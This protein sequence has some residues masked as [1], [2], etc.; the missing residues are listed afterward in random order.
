MG[1]TKFFG[2][3][4]ALDNVSFEV[5]NGE[6]VGYVGLNG[7]GKT[8]T[9]R[10]ATGVLPPSSGDV[11]IDG[12]SIVRN[13][14]EASR[15]IGWVPEL[16]I[17]EGDFKALDYFAY[18]AGYYGYS[19]SEAR[20]L[21]RDLL[22]KFGLGEALNLKLSAYSQGMRK[23]FALA[24]SMINDPPNFLFDE[25]LNGLD[26]RGIAFFRELTLDF[27][28][29][30]RA[31]FF[32]SHILSEVEGLADRV[33]FI[34]KGRIIGVYSMEEVKYMAKPALV[35]KLS[36][37]RNEAVEFMKKYGEVVALEG[38]RYLVRGFIGDPGDVVAGLVKLGVKV[39]EVRREEKGLEDFFFELL[40]KAEGEH[41]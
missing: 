41:V 37:V 27:K 6:V 12:Y 35:L 19:S 36:G 20:R 18:L 40:R 14:R 15:L 22:E 32:S 16:P 25:V 5:R 8:T 7:A 17:F 28:K 10:I 13:K 38:G 11:F 21:G 3:F 33:V 24:V 23:R 4:K 1:V 30:G 34:H 29:Q 39:D 9:I 31:V 26:P 2:K